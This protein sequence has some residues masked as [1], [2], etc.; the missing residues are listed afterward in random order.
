MTLYQLRQHESAVVAPVRQALGDALRGLSARDRA[1][2]ALHLEHELSPGEM[3][4]LLRLT[5]NATRVA[6]H[7]ALTRVR[8][9]L[10]ARGFDAEPIP[11]HD[12]Q[13]PR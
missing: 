10:S 7:R 13:E 4:P 12:Q 5:P 8:A 6:L 11:S 1:L 2:V 3:A 9:E